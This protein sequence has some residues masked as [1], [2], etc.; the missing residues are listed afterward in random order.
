MS[1]HPNDQMSAH[2][3]T[4]KNRWFTLGFTAGFSVLVA[5]VWGRLPTFDPPA[6]FEFADRRAWFGI[7]NSMD[8][9]SNLAF[10]WVGVYWWKKV[11][12]FPRGRKDYGLAVHFSIYR[13]VAVV[14]IFTGLGS[15]WF[16]WNPNIETLFWDRLPMTLGFS[17]MIGLIVSDRFSIRAGRRLVLVLAFVA[18]T[19]LI[20]W[21]AGLSDLRPYIVLQYGGI[22]LAVTLVV[23][24]RRAG[25]LENSAIMMAFALYA[26]AKFF[27]MKD[28]T[29]F[30]ATG[31][32]VSGHTIKH[33]LAAAAIDRLFAAG[34]VA[35]A[36]LNV[37]TLPL[38]KKSG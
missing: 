30:E 32:Q 25:I 10:L 22:L 28:L 34:A 38:R 20:L 11:S 13:F 5:L 31:Q 33:L 21:N 23:L 7:R 19:H 9:L 15:M 37:R 8:V 16:H 3:S 35:R 24:R 27:E 2:P 6:Y 1:A 14:A 29:I 17:G 4:K 36:S 12:A 18:V 26:V